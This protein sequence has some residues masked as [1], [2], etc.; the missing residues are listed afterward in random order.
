MK[1]YLVSGSLLLA[2]SSA[3]SLAVADPVTWEPDSAVAAG[4]ACSSG[5]DTFVIQ[6]GNDVSMVFSNLGVSLGH[7][8]P[9]QGAGA[10]SV[11]VP[12]SVTAG[13]FPSTVTQTYTYGVHRTSGGTGS[14]AVALRFLGIAVDPFPLS[15]VDGDAGAP[16]PGDH[17]TTSKSEHFDATSAWAAHWCVAGRPASGVLQADWR[18]TAQIATAADSISMFVDGLSLRYD[19]HTA[20]D[21]CH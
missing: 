20:W 18:A 1:K 13:F 2:S 12:V 21:A 5:V 4:T 8:S 16:S 15:F 10:C 19:L 6:N 3:A 17:L 9:L 7:G 14:L 11:R